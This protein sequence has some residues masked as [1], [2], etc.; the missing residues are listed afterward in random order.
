MSIEDDDPVGLG[1]VV[2]IMDAGT[3]FSGPWLQGF[4]D[5]FKTVA[6]IRRRYGRR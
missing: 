2:E 5:S 1:Q 6:V 3:S 4:G